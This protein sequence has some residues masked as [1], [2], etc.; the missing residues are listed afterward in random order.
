MSSVVLP[1][2]WCNVQLDDVLDSIVGGGTPSKSVASYF[3]GK[4][5][6]MTVKDMNKQMLTDTVDHI[7]Q[8]AVNSSSTN[9]IPAGT[10]IVATRMSL[11]KIVVANFD[12]AI[13]QDLKALFVNRNVSKLYLIYWYR[14]QSR[15]IESLGTGTTVKGIRLEILKTLNFPLPP[16][17]EQKVIADKLDSLLAQVDNIKNRLDALPTIIKR[18][19]QSVLLA[20]VSGKLTEDWREANSVTNVEKSIARIFEDRNLAVK[21]KNNLPK[22]H[23]KQEE[24]PIP[25]TWK[26]VSLDSVTS[27]IV[28]GTHHTPTYLDSGVPFISVKDIR[29][30]TIDFSYTKYISQNEHIE[31]SKRCDVKIGDL[32]ITKSGTI[33]RTAIVKTEREFS[34]FVSVALLK[35]ASNLVNMEFINIALQKWINEIDVSS[36]V[37][38][39]AI[40]NLHLQD[41]RV[42]AIPFAPVEE[43][44]EIVRRVEQLFAYADQ[45]EQQV[46]T[47]QSRVNNLTQA[48]LAKAFRGELTADWRAANPHLISGENSAQALLAK[49]KAERGQKAKK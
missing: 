49:I 22:E 9:I 47:A 20:A 13:N 34:L 17:A 19:K 8:E 43:Q 40:K 48:I 6:W 11:G 38:G 46:K 35:P 14:S 18:F 28:D 1:E 21:G 23:L 31:L 4:I 5:P 44:T 36:R 26:W 25:T 2:G 45:I 39:S 32:L 27:K 3:E 15:L 30:G 10:P 41:M 16:L 7:T 29:N 37:V 42:L 24:F 12:S 33:G